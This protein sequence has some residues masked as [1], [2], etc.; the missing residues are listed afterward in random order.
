M[1]EK[2]N[3]MLPTARVR[4]WVTAKLPVSRPWLVLKPH[5]DQILRL[6][7]ATLLSPRLAEFAASVILLE[8]AKCEIAALSNTCGLHMILSQDQESFFSIQSPYKGGPT[9]VA[10]NDT[11]CRCQKRTENKP[12]ISTCLDHENLSLAV[13]MLMPNVPCTTRALTDDS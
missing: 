10:K 2:I 5:F 13:V 3:S 7:L 9:P 8:D 11:H 4:P 1:Y 6:L 12:L